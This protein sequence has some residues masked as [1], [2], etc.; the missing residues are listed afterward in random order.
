VF[1]APYEMGLLKQFVIH[2]LSVN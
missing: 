1:T 2:L